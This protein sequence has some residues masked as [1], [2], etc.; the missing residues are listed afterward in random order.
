VVIPPNK[1]V[2]QLATGSP[3]QVGGIAGVMRDSG[4]W[5]NDHSSFQVDQMFLGFD[6]S[7]VASFKQRAV[8]RMNRMTRKNEPGCVF[9][10]WRT[11]SHLSASLRSK[12]EK[13]DLIHT[14]K[15]DLWNALIL[16]K[17]SPIIAHFHSAD[18]LTG[19]CVL[20]GDC[21]RLEHGC[22]DCPV[23]KS[24]AKMLPRLNLKRRTQWLAGAGASGLHIVVNSEWTQSVAR[25]SPI[26][27]DDTPISLIYPPYDSGVFKQDDE[28]KVVRSK[29][30]DDFTLGFVSYSLGDTNK[31]FT[32]FQEVLRVLREH[33]PVRGLAIGGCDA[34]LM[35]SLP[36]YIDL[37][38]PV[39]DRQELA[40]YYR[41]MDLL[42][43]PSKSESFGRISIEA[44][45][46][47]TPVVCYA[48]GG[49][50]ETIIDGQSGYAVPYGDVKSMVEASKQVLQNPDNYCNPTNQPHQSFLLQ[51]SQSSVGAKQLALYN[52]IFGNH[53]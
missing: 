27:P 33:F 36:D 3:S 51:F 53:T 17:I 48:V 13:Y 26:L 45:A 42:L 25:R 14:H 16:A 11:V 30:S 38:P 19:G 29:Q 22:S 8:H 12:I 10:Y 39:D 31:G 52:S 23:V 50:P 32:D 46:C 43:V 47:G 18:G 41:S 24:W 35:K 44:Q 15:V 34:H 37:V 2:L 21:E 20:N 1:R 40:C 28:E 49:L 6:D 4:D 5:M 7:V 9:N